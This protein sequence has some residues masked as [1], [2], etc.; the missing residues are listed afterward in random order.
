MCSQCVKR[1]KALEARRQ[2]QIDKGHRR[3]AAMLGAALAIVEQV[4][5]IG[6]RNRAAKADR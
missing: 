3:R 6:S 2:A 1:R 5:S 4:D